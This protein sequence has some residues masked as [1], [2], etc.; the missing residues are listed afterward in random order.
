MWMHE[1]SDGFAIAKYAKKV[2]IGMNELKKNEKGHYVEL[3]NATSIYFCNERAKTF[4]WDRKTI[5][6]YNKHEDNKKKWK[7]FLYE[8]DT[9][10]L[11]RFEIENKA[12]C[13]L[14]TKKRIQNMSKI[15][16]VTVFDL[17]W[18]IHRE[19]FEKRRMIVKNEKVLDFDEMWREIETMKTTKTFWET[20]TITPFTSKELKLWFETKRIEEIKTYE[21]KKEAIAVEK[22]RN[23]IVR[24]KVTK[25][26]MTKIM[27]YAM[28]MI[29]DKNDIDW[30]NVRK[31]NRNVIEMKK[32]T[33]FLKEE[34][35]I[36]EQLTNEEI[37][38]ELQNVPF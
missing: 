37:Q 30:K 36:Y 21:V 28:K 35:E 31:Q 26:E 7:T 13:I 6:L 18:H 34:E 3:S 8:Y 11:K 12:K 38:K 24:N 29:Y 5:R 25:Q 9:D 14:D 20:D 23:F 4:K 16:V 17:V 27:T 2:P 15:R 22:W 10:E 32:T 33:D 19:N 1:S